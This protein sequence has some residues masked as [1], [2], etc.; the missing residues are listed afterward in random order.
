MTAVI[1]NRLED[2]KDNSKPRAYLVDNTGADFTLNNMQDVCIA[3]ATIVERG[4]R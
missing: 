1:A 3:I 2:L 4:N